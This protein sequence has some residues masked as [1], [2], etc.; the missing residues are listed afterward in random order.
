MDLLSTAQAGLESTLA[1]PGTMYHALLT[2]LKGSRVRIPNL[3]QV[4]P[5]WPQGVNPHMEELRGK[6][7]EFID[8]FVLH[9]LSACLL[10]SEGDALTWMI[11]L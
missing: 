11:H 5:T 10:K 7:N 6:V 8:R 3:T 1:M 2:R 9:T 4:V